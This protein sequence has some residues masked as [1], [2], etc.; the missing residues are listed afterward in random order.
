MGIFGKSHQINIFNGK[1]NTN[2][3]SIL[4]LETG[5]FLMPMNDFFPLFVTTTVEYSIM[6]FFTWYLKC[7]IHRRFTVSNVRG[8][9]TGSALCVNRT[10]AS[11]FTTNLFPVRKTYLLETGSLPS[12]GGRKM[13][14]AANKPGHTVMTKGLFSFPAFRRWKRSENIKL[15]NTGKKPHHSYWSPPVLEG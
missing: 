15:S 4:K 1:T 13:L 14:H 3:E 8:T 10:T 12:T 11:S 2:T 5:H 6:V 9:L 7:K